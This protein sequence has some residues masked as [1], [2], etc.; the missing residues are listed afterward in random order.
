[1]FLPFSLILS[2]SKSRSNSIIGSTHLFHSTPFNEHFIF[3]AYSVCS[4]P[5]TTILWSL[6]DLG[7][8]HRLTRIHHFITTQ[9]GL[10]SMF[11][12]FVWSILRMKIGNLEKSKIQTDKIEFDSMFKIEMCYTWSFCRLVTIESRQSSK[13]TGLY[14][15]VS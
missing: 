2:N 4:K 11:Q 13:W 8:Y 5:R 1:M 3:N 15:I 6:I 9:I 12:S 7:S 10:A 14:W